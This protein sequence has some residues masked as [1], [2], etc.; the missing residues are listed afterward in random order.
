MKEWLS[1]VFTT[2]GLGQLHVFSS[3]LGMGGLTGDQ[4]DTN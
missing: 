2:A 4:N 3:T 1:H